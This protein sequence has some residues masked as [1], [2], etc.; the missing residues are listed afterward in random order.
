MGLDDSARQSI[1]VNL[2]CLSRS[3]F[4]RFYRGKCVLVRTFTRGNISR[5]LDQSFLE[6][7]SSKSALPFER[8]NPLDLEIILA[9]GD[10][11]PA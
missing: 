2:H 3:N 10:M 11:L 6:K 4:I 5:L 8:V 7:T 1:R 9:P